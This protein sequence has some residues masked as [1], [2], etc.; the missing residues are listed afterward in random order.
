MKMEEFNQAS[1]IHGK[2]RRYE[3]ILELLRKGNAVIAI[4]GPIDTILLDSK[5]ELQP[6][7]NA[8]IF[9]YENL[10][11]QALAEFAAL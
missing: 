10:L 8:L 3:N 5:D 4:S 6:S 11:E 9:L 1:V 2:V 7:K